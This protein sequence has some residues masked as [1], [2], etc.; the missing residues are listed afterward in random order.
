MPTGRF[1]IGSELRQQKA[2][3]LGERFFKILINFFNVVL[4]FRI[5]SQADCDFLDVRMG[6]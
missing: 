6:G 3:L 2:N 5:M 1:P 4:L